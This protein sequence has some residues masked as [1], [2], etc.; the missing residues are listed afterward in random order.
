MKRRGILFVLTL[1]LFGLSRFVYGAEE[2]KIGVIDFQKIVETS[3]AGKR[4]YLALKNKKDQMEQT[5]KEK[6]DEVGALRKTLEKKA[7]VM[8]RE[9][10]DE[11]ERDLRIKRI[12]LESLTKRYNDDIRELELKLYAQIQKDVLDIVEKIGEKEGYLL[13]LERRAG[14]ALYVPN[15]LDMTDRVIEAYNALDAKRGNK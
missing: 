8:N 2:V 3:T 9:A 13:I 7:L 4:S 5:L 10:R 1:C 12:E 6:E 14:G 15:A 11:S